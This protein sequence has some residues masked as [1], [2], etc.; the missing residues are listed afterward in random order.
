M[1]CC[2][3]RVLDTCI[4]LEAQVGAVGLPSYGIWGDMLHP[5]ALLHL[6]EI[7]LMRIVVFRVVDMRIYDAMSAT[8]LVRKTAL[9]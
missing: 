2:H 1:P 7:Q 5:V 9:D 4:I 3:H 6:S 8:R